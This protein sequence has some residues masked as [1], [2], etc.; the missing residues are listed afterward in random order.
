[1]EMSF[2]RSSQRIVRLVVNEFFQIN[3]CS[4]ISLGAA[5]PHVNLVASLGPPHAF[6]SHLTKIYQADRIFGYASPYRALL[7]ADVYC[8]D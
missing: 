3:L 5:R 8:D 6:S 2:G 4:I 7:L 1:M